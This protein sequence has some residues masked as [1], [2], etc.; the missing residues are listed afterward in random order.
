[1]AV[2][3]GYYISDEADELGRFQLNPYADVVYR[4]LTTGEVLFTVYA[5]APEN[6]PYLGVQKEITWTKGSVRQTVDLLCRA[7]CS[8]VAKSARHSS[9][10]PS[11]GCRILYAPRN[12][13]AFDPAYS[14][15]TGEWSAVVSRPD[16]TYSI[17]VPDGPGQL[18]V[19][20]ASPEYVLSEYGSQSLEGR[21]G[22][23][24][25]YAQC[26]FRSS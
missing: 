26:W 4:S 1:M 10:K 25:K 2:Q 21:S 17:P 19:S 14:V 3:G 6:Q 13:A 15:L 18:I 11:K 24:R 9:L 7:A 20:Q 5:Y 8:S 12:R 22:G 23:L 16:G